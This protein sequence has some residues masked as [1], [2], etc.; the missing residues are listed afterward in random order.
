MKKIQLIQNQESYKNIFD[1]LISKST[2]SFLVED[3]YDF[4]KYSAEIISEYLKNMPNPSDQIIA[5]VVCQEV[6]DLLKTNYSEQKVTSPLSQLTGIR[7]ILDPIIKRG[8]SFMT[9]EFEEGYYPIYNTE[10]GRMIVE[11]Y[12]NHDFEKHKCHPM[13]FKTIKSGGR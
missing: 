13:K 6:L 3:S 12:N 10:T 5:F 8:Y 1:Q 4:K 7:L 2:N 11:A 9:G